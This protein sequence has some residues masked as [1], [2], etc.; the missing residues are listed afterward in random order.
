M[1]FFEL[2]TKIGIER[3]DIDVL[4]DIAN[5]SGFDIKS[6][7]A[8]I[9]GGTEGALVAWIEKNADDLVN[10]VEQARKADKPAPVRKRVSPAPAKPAVAKV[11]VPAPAP[12]PAAAVAAP[13]EAPAPKDARGTLPGSKTVVMISRNKAN[14]RVEVVTRTGDE[15]AVPAQEAVAD[16]AVAQAADA[17]AQAQPASVPAPASAKIEAVPAA[18]VV[19]AAPVV[20]P[21]KDVAASANPYQKDKDAKGAPK[22]SGKQIPAYKPGA[23]PAHSK[24][25]QSKDIKIVR[26]AVPAPSAP[27]GPAVILEDNTAAPKPAALH[28][29][30]K[31]ADFK[32][33]LTRPDLPAIFSSMDSEYT[34]SIRSTGSRSRGGSRSQGGAMRRKGGKRG[35]A[36]VT[37]P[38]DPNALAELN[39]AM[40]LRDLSVALG[41]K[42]NSIMSFLMQGGKLLAV[43][44]I[45]GEEDI[46]LVAEQFAIPYQWK[47]EED[48]EQQLKDELEQQSED[49]GEVKASRPPVVTFMGHV[50]HGK[51]SLLDKIRLTRVAEGEAGGITQHIGAY[52]VEKNGHRITFLDTPGHEAFTQMR[53]RGANITDVV[54]LVVAADDGV[55]P[56][57]REAYNHAKNAGVPVVVALNKCD[58]PGANP[59]KVRQELA[60]QLE[61][62]P[63]EWGGHT[64]MIEVSAITGQ[65]IETLL[66]RILLEAEMLELSCNP[67][68]KALGYVIESEM[69]ENRGVVAT[70]LVLDGTLRRGDVILTSNGY[71]KVKLM[72]DWNGKTTDE[73][74]PS[75]AVSVVGLNNVPE[76][77]DKI[78][79]VDD[80][81]NARKLAEEREHK[82]R[83][84]ALSRQKRKHVT[85]ENLTSYLEE[86]QKRELNIII[87]ADVSGSLEVLEKTL[88]DLSTD[89]VS[90]NVIHSG[91]GGISQADVILAD[92]SDA[93]VVGFHVVADSSAKLQASSHNVQIKVYHIIYRLIEDM[94]AALEGMLPPEEREVI[95][96]QVEIRE[97][98][99]S[100]KLGNIAGCYV[101]EG[102]INRG[103]KVRLIRDHVVIYTGN[104]D[105]LRR[106]KDDVKEVRSGFECG[107]RIVG[108]DDI[109]VGDIIEAFDIEE[110]ARK[111]DS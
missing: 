88:T 76:V 92:A 16:A 26:P 97:V 48:L 14:P 43:N 94:R 104:I 24:K 93:L 101:T 38:R 87:K 106:V 31:R 60:T 52:S 23:Q 69:T 70:M 66:E 11:E 108:Y 105:G 91:V 85:L 102:Y 73:G 30:L 95:R 25:Q 6:S 110:I 71:G 10:K 42:L 4:K 27:Q 103:C 96:G 78:F 45:L 21:V 20:A 8:V 22:T 61:L 75:Q 1:R 62:M 2:G 32:G 83:D 47:Q 34:R 3:K 55:M 44:D 36:S 63:E 111:L 56:Q 72:Y 80:M 68:R 109:K 50:D 67:E 7:L 35:Q 107:M 29:K 15:A 41:V 74:G 33:T 40:S 17:S 46:V 9:D 54:V 90:I 77:G 86:G 81:I 57:T 53:A 12:A 100:S 19:T 82:A 5:Q 98:F 49:A 13:V 84:Q 51:T 39:K 18:P 99:H 59:D 64:G 65:G 37:L 58:M 28:S 89:E 79:V